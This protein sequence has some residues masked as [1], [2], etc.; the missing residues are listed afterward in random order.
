M[1]A[2]V[3]VIVRHNERTKLVAGALD[4]LALAIVGAGYLVPVIPNTLPGNVNAAVTVFWLL[5]GVCLWGVA[6]GV[7]EVDLTMLLHHWLTRLTRDGRLPLYWF[8]VLVAGAAVILVP[9]VA[10]D[11]TWGVLVYWFILPAAFTAVIV[12]GAVMLTRPPKV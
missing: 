4:K 3:G 5:L 8:I 7:W 11:L 2:A 9:L 6:L 10:G 12:V 1:G